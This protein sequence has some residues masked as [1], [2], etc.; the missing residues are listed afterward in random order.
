MDTRQDVTPEKFA[1]LV[2]E[3]MPEWVK[4]VVR[5]A[6]P[7]Q[8]TDYH[9]LEKELQDLLDEFCVTVPGRTRDRSDTKSQEDDDAGDLFGAGT[10]RGDGASDRG[11]SRPQNKT[12][13]EVPEGATST[14]S[15]EIYDKAPKIQELLNDEDIEGKGLRNRAAMF[16]RGG[17]GILFVNGKYDAV[18]RMIEALLPEFA[19]EEDQEQAREVI[20]EAARRSQCHRVGKAAVFAMSKRQADAWSERDMEAALSKETLSIAADD[21]RDDLN[22]ARKFVRDRLRLI[23]AAAA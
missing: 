13:H 3:L 7:H 17:V 18:D 14:S 15:A 10:V 9:D 4:E 16:V 12:L 6:S 23:R 20:A 1:P 8:Q 5:A 2:R 19:A 22:S 21:Y 11:G